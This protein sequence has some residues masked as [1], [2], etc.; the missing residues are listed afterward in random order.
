MDELQTQT[1]LGWPWIPMQVT[2]GCL[3]RPGERSGAELLPGVPV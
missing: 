1:R 2:A 3:S